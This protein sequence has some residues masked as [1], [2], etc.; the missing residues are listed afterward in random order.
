[1]TDVLV[2]TG[3]HPFEA[4]PFFAVFDDLAGVEWAHAAQ[5][6]AR[7]HFAADRAGDYDCIVCYDMPGITFTGADPPAVFEEPTPALV[8][9]YAGLLAAGQGIV[10]LH[11]AIA[12]WPAWPR[13]ADI[14]GGRFHYQPAS[15][16]GVDYPDSGYRFDV[17]HEVEVLD[18][19]HPVCAGL[20]DGF[21]L[22]DELYLYPVFEREV[23][24]LLRSRASFTDEHF[25]SADLAIRGDMHSRARWSHPPGSHLVGWATSAGRS[26][27]VYLQFGD[28]PQ[29]YADLN[30]RRVLGNAIAWVASPEACEWAA[31]NN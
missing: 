15:L 2:V 24:P 7:A 9:D 29:T 21:T 12:S 17:T 18:A 20:G 3:G 27:I 1:M 22:T 16:R 31:G 23:V 5:P 19:D 25:F 6:E 13:F 4:E 8:A 30:F 26:P 14:V 28:G 11:H 10:Y